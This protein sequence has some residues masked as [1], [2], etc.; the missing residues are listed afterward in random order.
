MIGF[1][2]CA[3]T[4][5]WEGKDRHVCVAVVELQLHPSVNVTSLAVIT[6]FIEKMELRCPLRDCVNSNCS[7]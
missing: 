5:Y 2:A 4:G 1:L 7:L 3:K 6:W